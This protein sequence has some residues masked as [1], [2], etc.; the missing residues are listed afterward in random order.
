MLDL[1][2]SADKEAVV[3]CTNDKFDGEYNL[4]R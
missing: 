1:L 2:I 3:S 4:R